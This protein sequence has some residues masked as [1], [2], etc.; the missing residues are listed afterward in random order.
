MNALNVLFTK[1]DIYKNVPIPMEQQT[2]SGSKSST[3]ILHTDIT[4]INLKQIV[5]SSEVVNQLY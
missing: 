3:I 1:Q 4:F 2:G 5:V